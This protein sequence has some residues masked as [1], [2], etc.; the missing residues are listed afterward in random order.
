MQ[1]KIN[2]SITV[3]FDP[4]ES[5]TTEVICGAATQ[6]LH[7][8]RESWGLESPQDCRIYI[9]TSWWG[10]FFQSAPWLWRILLAASFPLWCFRARRT[11]PYSAAWTQRYGRRVVIGIKPPSLLE[12]SDKR[13]GKL[14]YVDEKDAHTKIRHLTCHELTHACSAHLKLPAWLN[15][16]LAAVTVDRFLE[17]QTIRRDTLELLRKYTPKGSPPTYAKLSRLDAEAIAYYAVLG[18]WSVQ[19]L[20]ELHPGFL[21]RLFSSS[22]DPRKIENEIAVQ[23]GVEP[24]GFWVK[25]VPMLF[26]H[27]ESQA[28]S[29]VV[30]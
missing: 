29:T 23:L 22:P 15:E 13:V 4:S 30:E 2:G 16:G 27:F 8:I 12:V 6:A 28:A 9:M 11:W 21:K 10:F 7:L 19:F 14:M 26:T 1:S 17:K 3:F 18:Y 24:D 25:I 20:E 5:D